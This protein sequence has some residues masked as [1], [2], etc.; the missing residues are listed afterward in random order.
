M[1]TQHQHG[2]TR[3]QHAINK[4]V[5]DSHSRAIDLQG[6]DTDKHAPTRHLHGTSRTNMTTTRTNKASINFRLNTCGTNIDL[7]I[8]KLNLNNSNS[9]TQTPKLG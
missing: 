1:K 5:P 4:T 3:Q 8:W 2:P 9:W 7:D 6:R